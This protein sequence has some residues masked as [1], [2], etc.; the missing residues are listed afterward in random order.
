MLAVSAVATCV[1]LGISKAKPAES[2]KAEAPTDGKNELATEHVQHNESWTSAMTVL[3][4]FS[5]AGAFVELGLGYLEAHFKFLNYGCELAND[6]VC[7]LSATQTC[8]HI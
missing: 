7:C 2:G 6:N 1:E 5:A 4:T 3:L 8:N